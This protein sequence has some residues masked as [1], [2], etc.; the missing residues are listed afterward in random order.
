[1]TVIDIKFKKHDRES[2]LMVESSNKIDAIIEH[3]LLH[4]LDLKIVVGLLAHR[5]GTLVAASD[6]PDRLADVACTVLTDRAKAMKV[7]D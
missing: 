6:D 1:V 2:K 3:M 4:G 5:V 7:G